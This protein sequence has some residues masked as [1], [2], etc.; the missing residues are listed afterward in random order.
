MSD[1]GEFR[2]QEMFLLMDELEKKT[3]V[4]GGMSARDSD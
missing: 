1:C 4:G 2:Q 3:E